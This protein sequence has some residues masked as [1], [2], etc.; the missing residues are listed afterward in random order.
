MQ[1]GEAPVDPPVFPV[2][3]EKAK[4]TPVACRE[5]VEVLAGARDDRN[6]ALIHR[7]GNNEIVSDD[8]LHTTAVAAG[9]FLAVFKKYFEPLP[10]GQNIPCLYQFAR[11]QKY[12]PCS[13]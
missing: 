6:M 2:G 10:N 8:I 5:N 9:S 7:H 3:A 11:H 13:G 4:V 1:N 12:P